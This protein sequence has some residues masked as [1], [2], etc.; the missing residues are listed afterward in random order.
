L[1]RADSTGVPSFERQAQVPALLTFGRR[2]ENTWAPLD[3]WRGKKESLYSDA[4]NRWQH[5]RSI[6]STNYEQVWAER[7]NSSDSIAPCSFSST[8]LPFPNHVDPAWS[9][10]RHCCAS[11]VVFFLIIWFRMTLP[12]GC[13]IHPKKI[14]FLYFSLSISPRLLYVCV[15]RCCWLEHAAINRSWCAGSDR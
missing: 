9:L 14:F 5:N 13:C 11:S 2:R 1:M 6:R 4:F 12:Q 7:L 15:Y 8:C 10:T 3:P